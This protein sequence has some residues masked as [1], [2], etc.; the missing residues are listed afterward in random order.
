MKSRAHAPVCIHCLAISPPPHPR[1][2][3]FHVYLNLIDDMAA[4]VRSIPET[5]A[6]LHLSGTGQP[7]FSLAAQNDPADSSRV[8]LVFGPGRLTMPDKYV[9]G[10]RS[11]RTG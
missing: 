11:I 7:F 2:D 8:V 1:S 3:L 4:G 10:C 9:T 6:A 5:L